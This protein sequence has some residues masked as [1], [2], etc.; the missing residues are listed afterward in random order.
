MKNGSKSQIKMHQQ[1]FNLKNILSNAKRESTTLNTKINEFQNFFKSTKKIIK[2]NIYLLEKSKTEKNNLLVND[3]KNKICV[4]LKEIINKF[5]NN[6][7]QINKKKE[8]YKKIINQKNNQLKCLINKLKYNELKHEKD[9]LYQSIK[10]KKSI[11]EY[12]NS[13]AIYEK[14]ISF[15]FKPVNLNYFDNIYKVTIPNFEKHQPYLETINKNK[16][17]L[18]KEQKNNKEAAEKEILDLNLCLEIKNKKAVNF[19]K[20]KGF[21]F[22]FQN[23]KNKEKYHIDINLIE[24]INDSS[25]SDSNIDS[26]YDN[27]NIENEDSQDDNLNSTTINNNQISKDN[28]NKLS[29]SLSNKETNDQEKEISSN[30]IYLLNKLIKLKEKYNKLIEEKYKLTQEKELKEKK[31]NKA[32]IIINK[33]K[34]YIKTLIKTVNIIEY[35]HYY[36]KYN[37][38]IKS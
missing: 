26:D 22:D 14:D 37:F 11:Y 10:E 16:N 23:I 2:E 8:K 34:E 9:L 3:I 18:I 20:E 21:I 25:E 19:I 30:N 15:L 35:K 4:E 5:K 7:A 13:F 32:K 27:N 28:K 38:L 36:D 29:I 31:L 17:L 33:K 6:N 12:L 1:I 24:D